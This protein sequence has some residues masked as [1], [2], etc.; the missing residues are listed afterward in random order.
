MCP[1][2]GHP[3]NAT[4]PAFEDIRRPPQAGDLS[5]CSFC[6]GLLVFGPDLKRRKLEEQ[7]WVALPMDLKMAVMAAKGAVLARSSH[8]LEKRKRQIAQM[9]SNRKRWV[10][11]HPAVE[12][13]VQFNFPS[14]VALVQPISDAVAMKSVT[15][16][17]A[18]LELL[19]ALWPWDSDDEPTVL[20]VREVLE[21]QEP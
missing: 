5:I 18:G 2:C 12:V 20:M 14:N 1:E 7:D 21:N 19:K 9:L 15:C 17:A 6:A 13:K 16:N 11:A 3:I 4:T 8:W 10:A